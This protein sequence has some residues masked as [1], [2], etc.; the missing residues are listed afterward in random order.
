MT[1][2]YYAWLP[3]VH[4]YCSMIDTATLNVALCCAVLQPKVRLSR[5]PR[6]YLLTDTPLYGALLLLLLGSILCFVIYCVL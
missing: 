2:N 1:A 5:P 6:R 3:Y 4:S